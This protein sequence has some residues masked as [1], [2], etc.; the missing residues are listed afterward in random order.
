M[1]K[2]LALLVI[3]FLALSCSSDKDDSNPAPHPTPKNTIELDDLKE[4]QINRYLRYTADCSD[5]EGTFTYTGDT[6]EISTKMTTE[7]M[8]FL[9]EFTYGSTEMAGLEPAETRV[10]SKDGYILI[11]ERQFSYLF[12][13]FGNDTLH[14]DKPIDLN[15]NQ[16]TCFIEYENSE[17]FIGEEIGFLPSF[18]YQD[19]SY[20]NNRI[21]SCVPPFMELDA[22]LI[23]DKSQLKMSH[24]L[25]D[26]GTSY[27]IDG[28]TLLR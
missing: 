2:Y 11:P 20:V 8:A 27:V 13:F 3:P 19:I 23:Y 12:F 9:E 24:T 10:I 6:L 16:G 4:G 25:R 1:K 7:G 5:P 26:N 28:Y 15:L 17:P 14:L 18:N 21:V 22:Y